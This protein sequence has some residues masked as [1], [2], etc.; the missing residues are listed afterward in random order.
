LLKQIL[1]QGTFPADPHP[2][3]VLVLGG[4]ELALIDFGSVGRLDIRL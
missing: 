3:N 1:I 4:G 2:G